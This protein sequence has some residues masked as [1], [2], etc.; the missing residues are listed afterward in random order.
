[1]CERGF[2]IVIEQYRKN[3]YS[4]AVEDFFTSFEDCE[5]HSY[6]LLAALA[7]IFQ[8]RGLDEIAIHLSQASESVPLNSE[9]LPQF[10]ITDRSDVK[11]SQ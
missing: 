3:A 5:F 7:D 10:R 1:M 4:Q 11:Q 9:A 6:E 2:E 8:K